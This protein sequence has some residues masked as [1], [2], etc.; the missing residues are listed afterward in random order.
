MTQK[1]ILIVDDEKGFIEALEDALVYEGYKVLTANT[2]A[3]AL[4]ILKNNT[5]DLATIDVMMPPGK[6]LESPNV[7]SHRT[8]I[9]LLRTIK[10][11]YPRLDLFCISVIS[12]SDTIREIQ[13]IGAR[14]LR[15]GETSLRTILSMIKSRLTGFA[16]L[17]D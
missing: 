14:F 16:Y 9:I 2:A 5:V 11:N 12:E 13:Q 8:G 17:D 10:Q 15:K 3:D 6:G 7:D 1:T 4:N